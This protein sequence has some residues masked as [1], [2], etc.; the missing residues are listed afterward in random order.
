M[1]N[2]DA[3]YNLGV[4]YLDGI[5]PGVPGRNQVRRLEMS[6]APA[7]ASVWQSCA[8]GPTQTR[9]HRVGAEGKDR[10]Q[11]QDPVFKELRSPFGKSGIEEE[12]I[13]FSQV[14]DKWHDPDIL[15]KGIS[16]NQ[17]CQ[18]GVMEEGGLDVDL[19]LRAGDRK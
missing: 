17:S 18:E 9:H 14:Y 3:S 19:G 10:I 6:C 5:F 1:G 16:E 8:E 13:V 2:P 7:Q 11:D 15:K 12:R 4:L